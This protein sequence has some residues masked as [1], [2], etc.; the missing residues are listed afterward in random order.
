MAR[1]RYQKAGADGALRSVRRFTHPTNGASYRIL[2]NLKEHR[3][4]IVDDVSEIIAA[5]GL[6]V[7]LHKLKMDVRDALEQLGIVLEVEA[8][9]KRRPKS[10]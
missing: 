1:I 10:P 5:S 6:R 3:W 9:A 2:L 7:H 8:R 4:M